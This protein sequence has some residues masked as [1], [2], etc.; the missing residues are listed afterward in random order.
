[1]VADLDIAGGEKPVDQN[2]GAATVDRE[3]VVGFEDV[4]AFQSRG[5]DG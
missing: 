4:V 1:V 5:D 2:A 3:F